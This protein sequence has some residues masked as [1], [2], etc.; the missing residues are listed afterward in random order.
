MEIQLVKLQF[1]KYNLVKLQLWNYNCGNTI[2]EIQFY[3]KIIKELFKNY[4]R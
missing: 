3:Q 4:E 2:V 1:G